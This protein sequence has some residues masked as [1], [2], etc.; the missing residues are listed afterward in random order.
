MRAAVGVAYT[1][2]LP[3]A[4]QTSGPIAPDSN[5]AELFPARIN[6]CHATCGGHDNLFCLAG[7]HRCYPWQY[8]VMQV[9]VHR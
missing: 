7:A 6:A 4:K 8:I 2:S 1:V 9:Y 5:P 3:L